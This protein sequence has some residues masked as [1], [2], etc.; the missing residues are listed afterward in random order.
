MVANSVAEGRDASP[1]A[2]SAMSLEQASSAAVGGGAWGVLDGERGVAD[3]AVCCEG[4]AAYRWALR[5]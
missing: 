4:H 3:G 5:L 1:V 2:V